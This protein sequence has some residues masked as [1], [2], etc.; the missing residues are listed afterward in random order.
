MANPAGANQLSAIKIIFNNRA[1]VQ[2]QAGFVLEPDLIPSQ[3][4]QKQCLGRPDFHRQRK[5]GCLK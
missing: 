1:F 2:K 4:P 5:K 3:H